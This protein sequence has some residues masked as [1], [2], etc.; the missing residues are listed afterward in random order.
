MAKKNTDLGSSAPEKKSRKRRWIRYVLLVDGLV[1][2]GVV[3]AIVAFWLAPENGTTENCPVIKLFSDGR[4]LFFADVETGEKTYSYDPET[5]EVAE[6]LDEAVSRCRIR[7]DS[8]FYSGREGLFLLDRE[9]GQKKLLLPYGREKREGAAEL[10]GEVLLDTPITEGCSDFCEENGLLCF[11]Y[12]ASRRLQTDEHTVVGEEQWI[13]L[14]SYDMKNGRLSAVKN[15]Y[16]RKNGLAGSVSSNGRFYHGLR[17]IGGKLYYQTGNDVLRLSLDGK[18]TERIY[19]A[20][21]GWGTV[22]WNDDFFYSVEQDTS[23]FARKISLDGE[24]LSSWKLEDGA[25]VP[26]QRSEPYYDPTSDLFYVY[27][28]R[29]LLGFS[30]EESKAYTVKAELTMEE[31]YSEAELLVLGDRV[32]IALFPVNGRVR[33]AKDYVIVEVNQK[34]EAVTVIKNGKPVSR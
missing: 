7:E 18:E 1:L 9:S 17:L 32:Y 8:V 27:Y 6:V 30:L 33:R 24:T 3:A 34:N 31:R 28:D 19:R 5:H 29:T 25:E 22:Y 13:T 20:E 10:N 26:F 11:V 21:G 4:L 12:R 15:D 23:L 16:K 2:L 14:Y